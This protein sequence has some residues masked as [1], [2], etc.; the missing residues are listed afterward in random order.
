M[1]VSVEVATERVDANTPTFDVDVAASGVSNL[2]A[3]QFTL[4]YDADILRYMEMSEAEDGLLGSSEREIY[5]PGKSGGNGT[6][7][8]SCV[9]LNPPV[10]Q[11]GPPGADGSGVL[12]TI[13]FHPTGEGRSDLV[14]SDVILLAAEVDEADEPIEFEI[15]TI[16]GRI[17]VSAGPG[18]RWVL[19][20]PV[21]AGG[22]LVLVAALLYGRRRLRRG[23]PA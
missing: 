20:G 7:H 15:E 22:A 6:V 17:E 4:D 21:I 1:T 23:S 13:T 10:S 8:L 3:F 16:N 11:G 12:A 19:W 5:C 18:F 9:T 2:A 14:L